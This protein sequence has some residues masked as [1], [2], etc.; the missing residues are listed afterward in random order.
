MAEEFEESFFIKLNKLIDDKIRTK[1]KFLEDD[2]Y[3]LL[4]NK[5]DGLINDKS[6]SVDKKV[7]KT[8]KILCNKDIKELQNKLKE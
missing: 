7:I 5:T 1:Q 4:F 3:A 6:K 8:L 2:I